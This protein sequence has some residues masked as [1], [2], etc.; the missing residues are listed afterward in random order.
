[1]EYSIA[2]V[3]ATKNLPPAVS[4]FPTVVPS[5]APGGDWDQALWKTW[6]EREPGDVFWAMES[7]NINGI[8]GY[9]GKL[10]GILMEIEMEYSWE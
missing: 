6:A 1:M 4:G 9:N 8:M 2:T 5:T 10:T 3:I 7:I